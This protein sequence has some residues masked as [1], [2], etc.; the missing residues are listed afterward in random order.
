MKCVTRVLKCNSSCSNINCRMWIDYEEDLN[1]THIAIKK[2]GDMTL[3]E[4]GGRLNLS[5]ARIKQ[6]EK[7]AL[8]KVKLALISI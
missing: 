4:V 5:Y 1:C 8:K 6:I 7:E 3:L 2:N